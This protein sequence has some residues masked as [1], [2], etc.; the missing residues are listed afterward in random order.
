MKTIYIVGGDGFA[1]ECLYFLLG[2]AK[3][4]GDIIFGGYLG[5]GGYGHTVNYKSQQYLYKGEVSEHKFGENEYV[6]IG[7][8]YPK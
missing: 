7:A 3:K 4:S 2:V 5:H 1:R 6:I 8:G